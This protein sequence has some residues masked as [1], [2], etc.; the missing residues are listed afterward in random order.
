MVALPAQGQAVSDPIPVS[1]GMLQHTC[2]TEQAACKIFRGFLG[3]PVGEVLSTSACE[4]Q[5][6]GDSEGLAV[7]AALGR[8]SS[9]AWPELS[10]ARAGS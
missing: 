6:T 4:Q 10:C 8:G 7:L 5:G 2:V 9:C 3:K 1:V